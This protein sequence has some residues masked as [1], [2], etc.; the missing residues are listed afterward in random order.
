MLV[1]VTLSYTISQPVIVCQP[2]S[3][4]ENGDVV[5]SE[6]NNWQSVASYSCNTGYQLIGNEQRTCQLSGVWN[7]TEPM[8]MRKQSKN[9]AQYCTINL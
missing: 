4:V 6:G 9:I 3:P 7:G 2:L 1:M 8:C 5:F